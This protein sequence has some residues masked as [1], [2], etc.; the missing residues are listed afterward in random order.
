M[1]DRA[2]D[3]IVREQRA[4]PPTHAVIVLAATRQR[5]L[6][7][8]AYLREAHGMETASAPS[9]WQEPSGSLGTLSLHFKAK[10]G[11]GPVDNKLP[12]LRPTA[13]LG[14]KS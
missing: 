9:G 6:M 14:Q 10:T 7:I 5:V 8:A 1:L 2:N 12:G 3:R 4:S 13:V 11:G